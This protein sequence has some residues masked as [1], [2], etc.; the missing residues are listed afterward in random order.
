M[1]I[2]ATTAYAAPFD[3]KIQELFNKGYT[4]FEVSQGPDT[5]EIEA[6]APDGS[7][8][9][10]IIENQSGTTVSEQNFVGTTSDYSSATSRIAE[11]LS[12]TQVGV[13]DNDSNETHVSGVDNDSNETHVGGVDNDS[14]ETHVSGVDNDSNETHV[15]GVDNDSNETHV[16][17]VDND[18]NETH[19]GG[20]DN[21]SN[22]RDDDHNDRDDDHNDRD[23]DHNDRDDDW[24]LYNNPVI[25][26]V[27][28]DAHDSWLSKIEL[29]RANRDVGRWRS[30]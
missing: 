17:G 18:S 10:V 6:Y 23:D 22:D 25:S 7:K 8:S 19:V 16:G 11:R 9:V 13:V 5:S 3:A 1:S 26:L 28:C 21:D 24:I 14:N 12:D 20:V 27:V 15:G 2:T 30:L 29:M 4:H